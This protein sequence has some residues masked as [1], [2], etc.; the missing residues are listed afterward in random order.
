[1]VR[2][3][4]NDEASHDRSWLRRL[5]FDTDSNILELEETASLKSSSN[6]C[7]WDLGS[8]TSSYRSL[9]SSTHPEKRKRFQ[10]RALGILM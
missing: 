3:C 4:N 6:N 10:K 2:L 9:N 7:D 5:A 1:M 8:S